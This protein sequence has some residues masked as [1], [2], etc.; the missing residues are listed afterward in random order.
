MGTAGEEGSLA[1]KLGLKV[2]LVT[3]LGS[4]QEAAQLQDAK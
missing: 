4:I 2:A 3:A 1:A